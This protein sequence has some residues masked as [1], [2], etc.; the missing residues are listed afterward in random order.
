MVEGMGNGFDYLERFFYGKVF[1]FE[2]F[3]RAISVFW[4]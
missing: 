3:D 2:F 4:L 1:L